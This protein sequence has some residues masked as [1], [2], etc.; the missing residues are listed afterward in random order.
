MIKKS[1]V[2]LAL[3]VLFCAPYASAETGYFQAMKHDWVRG[4]KNVVGFP[5][6]IPV[7]IQKYHES[8]GYPVVRHLAGFTDGVFRAIV[9]AGSG[10][11][12]LVP[13]SLIPGIQEGLPVSPETLF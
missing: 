3:F 8:A 1:T 9:R 5:L 13:A 2:L 6:E 11:W 12:D 4:L 10:L 7:T